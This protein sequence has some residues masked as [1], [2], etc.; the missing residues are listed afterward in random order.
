M[1]VFPRPLISGLS[2]PSCQS[3]LRIAFKHSLVVKMMRPLVSAFIS[4][5]C[6]SSTSLGFSIP[7]SESTLTSD[8]WVMG[9]KSHVRHPGKDGKYTL[10]AEGIRAQFVPY[11][12][13]ISNLFVKDKNGTERDIVLGWDNATYYTGKSNWISFV[14]G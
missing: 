10:E 13:G 4:I 2:Q 11:G 5:C 9:N 6:L 8:S 7:R 3:C 1:R 14:L 12:A